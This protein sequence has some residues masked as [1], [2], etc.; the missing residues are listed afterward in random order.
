MTNN[1]AEYYGLLAGLEACKAV[2]VR[3]LSVRGDSQL[4]VK[5]VT[6]AEHVYG[7][8]WCQSPA[9]KFRFHAYFSQ[10]H[11]N[12]QVTLQVQG[13]YKVNNAALQDL[14][15]RVKHVMKSFQEFHI[16]HVLR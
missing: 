8:L 13:L 5:Q 1:Q 4:V 6:R 10:P 7:S 12:K 11:I 15:R 2:G 3:R 14:H 9:V 16:K